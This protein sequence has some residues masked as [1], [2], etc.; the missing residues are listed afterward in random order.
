MGHISVGV[1]AGEKSPDNAQ[2]NPKVL[3]PLAMADKGLA[4]RGGWRSEGVGGQRRLAVR[5]GWCKG[6]LLAI[7]LFGN[8]TAAT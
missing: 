3:V 7:C 1:K 8:S 5:G 4:V 2:Q 6:A